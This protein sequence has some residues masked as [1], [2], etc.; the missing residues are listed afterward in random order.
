MFRWWLFTVNRILKHVD[1]YVLRMKHSEYNYCHLFF[2][3]ILNFIL[4][5]TEPCLMDSGKETII[6]IDTDLV[7][8]ITKVGVSRSNISV[9]HAT[10][11]P[12][13]LVDP[14]QTDGSF[15]KK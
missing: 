5:Q 14:L 4:P 12:T 3:Y 8:S 1:M 11:F 7:T 15:L 2:K 13:E 6:L 9:E 10:A